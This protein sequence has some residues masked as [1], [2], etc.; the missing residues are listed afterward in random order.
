MTNSP[1]KLAPIANS[2]ATKPKTKRKPQDNITV[3]VDPGTSLTK[4]I[5][6]R[7]DG[8]AQS[9]TMGAEYCDLEAEEAKHLPSS[10][11]LGKPEDNAWIQE[12]LDDRC[13]A[14][15]AVAVDNDGRSSIKKLKHERLKFKVMAAIGAIARRENLGK[16]FK[17]EIGVM[18]PLNEYYLECDLES[19]L[20]SA[21][22][23]FYFQG[24]ELKVKLNDFE[25]VP[26]GHGI[27]QFTSLCTKSDYYHQGNM[28]AVMLGHRNTSCL[29]YRRGTLS[30]RE[31]RTSN[32][33]FNIFLDRLLE[34]QPSLLSHENILSAMESGKINFESL[35]KIG[36]PLSIEDK[37]LEIE[38]DYERALNWYWNRLK[39]EFEEILP[40]KNE[41]DAFLF[42]GGSHNLLSSRTQE[43]ANSMEAEWRFSGAKGQLE[44]YLLWDN[45]PE[46]K[47][48]ERE[49]LGMRFADAWGYF[50][51]FADYDLSRTLD[52]KT[53]EVLKK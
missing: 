42:S 10:S 1:V 15:G 36:S 9:M 27:V 22:S 17:A 20:K 12:N 18:M 38:K 6:N 14:I 41:I 24:Q 16:S 32:Y 40:S 28:A 25:S 47:R 45:A 52:P 11:A 29:F 49:N 7:N 21:L 48:F 51:S 23:S 37:A 39:D 35:A 2:T 8:L 26:E 13:Y 31:S 53:G 5:Y 4:I 3:I 19:S 43:Y 44:K 34:R 33:G 46:K 30:K 50:V